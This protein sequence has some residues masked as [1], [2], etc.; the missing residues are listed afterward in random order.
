MRPPILLS[1]SRMVTWGMRETSSRALQ[2]LPLT[3]I[4]TLCQSPTIHPHSTTDPD[5]TR[6]PFFMGKWEGLLGEQNVTVSKYST[7]SRLQQGGC[8]PG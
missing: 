2:L 7:I 4:P 6:V 8:W 5:G 1:A 3:P